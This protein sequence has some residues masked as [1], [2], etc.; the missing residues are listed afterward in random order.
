[1]ENGSI[2]YQVL[3]RGDQVDAISRR[4]I[5]DD[6]RSL[7]ED[8]SRYI[9]PLGIRVKMAT[10][11]EVAYG[12]KLVTVTLSDGSQYTDVYVAWDR[13]IT[14]VGRHESQPFDAANVVDVSAQPEDASKTD[15]A[16]EDDY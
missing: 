9:I 10:I 3:L 13:E 12:Y 14:A 6:C 4:D 1:M 15:R 8:K 16:T 5:A 2:Y 11:P 7:I